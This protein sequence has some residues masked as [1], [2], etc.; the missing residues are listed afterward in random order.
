MA[1]GRSN[2]VGFGAAPALLVVDLTSRLA[3]PD[4]PGSVPAGL[5]AAEQIARVLQACRARGL[6][7]FFTR[8]GKRW[9]TGSASPLTAA[10]RGAWRYKSDLV[11]E[12]PGDPALTMTIS[13]LVTPADGETLLTKS[14]PSAFFA[15]PLASYLLAGRVDTLIVTGM[16]TSGCVRATVTDAFSHDLRVIVPVECVADTDQRAHEANLHDIDKKYADVTA[17]ADVLRVLAPP[18]G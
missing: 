3:S 18:S 1:L 13:P 10:Q 5:D 4:H 11:P 16:M 14:K 2:R 15:T 12:G 17:V 8:G 6:P 7:V 9:H